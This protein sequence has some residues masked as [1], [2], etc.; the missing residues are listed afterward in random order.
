MS[1]QIA[2]SRCN[3]PLTHMVRGL[4]LRKNRPTI[5]VICHQECRRFAGDGSQRLPFGIEDMRAW[6]PKHDEDSSGYPFTLPGS[7]RF[8]CRRLAL[9]SL[10]CLLLLTGILDGASFD[11]LAEHNLYTVGALAE[12]LNVLT[13]LFMFWVVQCAQITLKTHLPHRRADPL[14]SFPAS[15]I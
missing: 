14:A 10:P 11:L 3:N 13:L 1:R 8:P 7:S 9:V 2:Q 4:F 6:S 5:S 12:A 15:S